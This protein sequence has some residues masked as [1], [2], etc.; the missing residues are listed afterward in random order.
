MK[1]TAP[2]I[3]PVREYRHPK[4]GMD[5]VQILMGTPTLGLIRMEWRNAMDSMAAPPNWALVKST[6]LGYLV[7]DA[8]NILV[9]DCLMGTFRALLLIEDDTCPPPHAL[10]EFD[11]WFWK[12]ERKLAPPIVSGLYHIKGTAERRAG[13]KGGIPQLGAEPLIY[14]GGGQRAYRD[15]TPGDV[16]WCSGIPTGALLIHRSVL[17]AWAKEPDIEVYQLEGYPHPL[18]R[19]FRNPSQVWVD[20]DTGGIHAS[21]G[22]S[23]LWWSEHTIQRNILK[24]AGWP[25]KFADPKRWTPRGGPY[26]VDTGMKFDHIDRNTGERW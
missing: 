20:P 3:A 24:K 8:Q 16:V 21:V 15:W 6:P 26:I 23:D 19:I 17:E 11:R 13:K 9:N 1:K 10:I 14:R 5:N 2:P 12:M 7:P 4:P 18:R 25:A 22:T